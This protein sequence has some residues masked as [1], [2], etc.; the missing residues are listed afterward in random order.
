M[1]TKNI[2]IK[3]DA[4]GQA[5]LAFF[6]GKYGFEVVERNDGY[7]IGGSNSQYFAEYNDWPIYEKKAIKC[8]KGKI[9][10]IGCGAGKHSLYLQKK[11]YDIMAIDS[12]PLAIQ[13]CRK[14]GVENAHIISI[15]TLN[16][17]KQKF[18]T[19]LLLGNNFGLLQNNKTA[20]KILKELYKITSDKAIIIA[21]SSNP[22][23]NLDEANVIYQKNNRKQ[24]R[25]SGQRKIRIRFREYTSSW[26]DY[27]GVSED[28]MKKIL[29]NANWQIKEIF[30]S[31]GSSYIALITKLI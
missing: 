17:I 6:N 10:D 7:V 27:L 22:Y 29:K 19:V 12:S 18:D 25:M 28:E 4:T 5:I 11:G 26:F 31:E 13:V 3:N 24:G 1:S 16:K 14:R 2:N 8:A 20:V 21:E 23:K 30:Y 15:N 9:L